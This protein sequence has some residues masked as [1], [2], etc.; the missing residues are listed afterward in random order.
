MLDLKIKKSI[1]TYINLKEKCQEMYRDLKI[2][3][4]ERILDI[5]EWENNNI[6]TEW[7]IRDE[8]AHYT[9]DLDFT[10]KGVDVKA[11]ISWSYGGHEIEHYF[12]PYDKLFSDDWKDEALY[13]KNQQELSN[14]YS[15]KEKLEKVKYLLEKMCEEYDSNFD[16]TLGE[17]L[18]IL[19]N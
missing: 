18:S 8:K 1:E 17:C 14:K 15:D 12:I 9:Y 3:V 4:V 16:K 6:G 7:D 19:N 2:V 10:K 5:L 11:N 13:N